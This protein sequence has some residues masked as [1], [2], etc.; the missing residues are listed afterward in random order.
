MAELN[1]TIKGPDLSGVI[2]DLTWNQ[3]HMQ[4]RLL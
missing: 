3:C 2:D 1:I 4:C